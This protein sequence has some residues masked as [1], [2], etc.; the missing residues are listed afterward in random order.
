MHSLYIL[1][2][3]FHLSPSLDILI[4]VFLQQIQ[5]ELTIATAYSTSF[6]HICGKCKSPIAP[7]AIIEDTMIDYV[8]CKEKH[9]LIYLHC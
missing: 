9:D 1:N 6:E 8:K 7:S 4:I 2:C 5:W 3:L